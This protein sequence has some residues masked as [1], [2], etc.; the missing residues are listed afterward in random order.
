MFST[1]QST[2]RCDDAVPGAVAIAYALAGGM[3]L[4]ARPRFEHRHS[5]PF[6]HTVR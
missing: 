2:A 4:D 3:K 1:W 6:T 5:I